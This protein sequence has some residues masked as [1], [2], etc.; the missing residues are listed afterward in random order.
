MVFFNKDELKMM[1]G[2]SYEQELEGPD[3][4]KC[5]LFA[6]AKSPRM[7][8]TGEGKRKTLIIA[9]QPGKKEDEKGIQLIGPAG[10][11]LR[12][13]LTPFGLDL[14]KDFWKINAL[15]CYGG[16]ITRTRLSC[17][18]PMIDMAVRELQP[19]HIWIMGGK[20]IEQ[21]YMGRFQNVAIGRWRGICIPD[22]EWNAWI[23]P[24]FHPS[25]VNRNIKDLNL[26]S[27]FDS[28]LINAVDMWKILPDRPTFENDEQ[29]V[30]IVTDFDRLMDILDEII[31]RFTNPVIFDYETNS[32]KANWS[33]SRIAT[34]SL[35]FRVRPD[36]GVRSY[37]FPLEYRTHWTP[38]QW[39][40]IKRRLRTIMLEKAIKK[41]A[42]NLKF[43]ESWTRH[44]LGV[45]SEALHWCTMNT[46][47][48]IDD[49]PKFT[50]L[51]FQSYI[52]FGAEDYGREIDKYL[53]SKPG[54]HFNRVM[55]ADLE[56][57]LLYNG[58]DSYY[59]HLLYDT[60]RHWFEEF[61]EL[62]E[63]QK[64]QHEGHLCMGDIQMNGIPIDKDYYVKADGRL[65]KKITIQKKQLWNTEEAK[66]FHREYGQPVD[67]GS[68]D[69]LQ[70]LF[71]DMG[72]KLPKQ[73]KTGY[74][75]DK[76][77]LAK[78]EHPIAQGISYLRKL[79]KIKG[80]Y[81]AQFLREYHEETKRIYPFFD[82]HTTQ[83][84]RSSSSEPNFQNIPVR[85]AEA[86]NY[87]RGGIIPSPGNQ[88]L[89]TDFGAQEVRI[90]CCHSGD[91]VLIR[92]T[93]DG[94][95]HRD[96]GFNLFGL[97]DAEITKDI[98][99]YAKNGF[100]FPELY[101]SYYVAC[102]R[103]LWENVVIGGLRTGTGRLVREHLQDKQIIGK[104]SN[105]YADFERHVQACEE[106]FWNKYEAHREWQYRTI[107][108][109]QEKGYVQLLFGH[110]RGGY[111]KKNMIINTPIQGDAYLC[112]QYTLVILNEMAKREGWKTQIIGQIHDSIL[113]NLHP[114][115][116]EYVLRQ[117]N[118]IATRQIREDNEWVIVPLLIEAEIAPVDAPWLLKQSING[119]GHNKDGELMT[120]K[121]IQWLPTN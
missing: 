26:H 22:R 20:A 36:V 11:L 1:E 9:E 65:A 40:A 118:R 116:T 52:Y 96:Q 117:I 25:Y 41:V 113:L 68:T 43:E 81:M 80:T 29:F 49:R 112:L 7:N 42:Q 107:R 34:M 31:E 86:R 119:N 27:V 99:F 108:S 67:W 82:T 95:M 3:C 60:Q 74:S 38:L 97:G 69:D 4:G 39:R 115:E 121:E 12:D 106:A 100:V 13:K 47:H 120:W 78:I 5:K 53:K 72:I 35:A 50:K 61:W 110:R 58:L 24:M 10:Q 90:A 109:Y 73:T 54:S 33:E 62:S 88:L 93:I 70:I 46:A 57:L 14:D 21:K 8:Y 85:D 91:P 103:E 32:L 104:G 92:D 44:R 64:I 94:D 15:N 55:Q 105:A 59:T 19:T 71:D 18:K 87:T 63:A 111:L 48:V 77:S 28:D 23:L 83:T 101:G 45:W 75:T 79:D 76:D 51:K 114:P 16:D 89:E 102:A 37:A 17:C 30:E 98:R 66:D 56:D 84:Y 2:A 6:F